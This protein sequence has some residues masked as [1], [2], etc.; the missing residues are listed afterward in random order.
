MFDFEYVLWFWV[1]LDGVI[2]MIMIG[3]CDFWFVYC[4][5]WDFVMCIVEMD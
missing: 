2:G 5:L 1:D 3:E 4:V